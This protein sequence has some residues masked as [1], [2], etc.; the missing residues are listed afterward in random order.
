MAE[1][2]DTT[3]T[4]SLIDV[5]RETTACLFAAEEALLAYY[6]EDEKAVRLDRVER[7]TAL[8]QAALTILRV[9]EMEG[10]RHG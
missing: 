8:V 2:N 6:S 5:K 7:A 3:P 4:R 1:N 10:V 9:M